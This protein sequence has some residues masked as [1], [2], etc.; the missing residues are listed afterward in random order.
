MFHE[1]RVRN[2]VSVLD[3]TNRSGKVAAP[4]RDK[5]RVPTIKRGGAGDEIRS[6][7]MQ[8]RKPDYLWPVVVVVV[9]LVSVFVTA[10]GATV[11]LTTTLL[12]TG[13]PFSVV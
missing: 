2:V 13:S 4:V 9:S 8:T 12:T 10:A 6:L 1:K 7:R 3:L 11:R 5:S